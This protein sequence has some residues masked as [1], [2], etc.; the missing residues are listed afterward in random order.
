[1]VD[2]AVMVLDAAQGIERE[3]RDPLRW[4]CCDID[5]R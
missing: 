4:L 5:D 3:R 2:S 1:V